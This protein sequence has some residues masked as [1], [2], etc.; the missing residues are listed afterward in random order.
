M[1]TEL[2]TVR[3]A[4]AKHHRW[5]AGQQWCLPPSSY[6]LWLI[7]SGNVVVRSQQQQWRLGAGDVFLFPP[8]RERFIT[9]PEGAEWLSVGLEAQLL[10]RVD[11]LMHFAPPTVWQPK[12]EERR[13]LHIWMEQI[14]RLFPPKT[15]AAHIIVNGLA[16]AI[17]GLCCQMLCRTEWSAVSKALLPHW[18]NAVLRR[19]RENPKVTIAELA[20]LAHFSPAQFRRLFRKWMGVSPRTYL[21]R[22]RLALSRQLLELTDLSITDIAA[23]CGFDSV[24]HFSRTFKKA[25]SI[26]PVVY[27]RRLKESNA[28]EPDEV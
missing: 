12:D 16:Q 6:A 22:H 20:Q 21:H 25:F 19:L 10:G 3:T 14:V 7:L 8:H 26:A 4:W 13:Q 1:I 11:F 28:I 24:S 27:R 18:L 17:V 2:L 23:Q 5:V 9:T 15:D